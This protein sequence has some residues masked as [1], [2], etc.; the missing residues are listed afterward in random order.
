MTPSRMPLSHSAAIPASSICGRDLG[1][2][3]AHAR[4]HGPHLFVELALQKSVIGGDHRTKV[5]VAGGAMRHEQRDSVYG[6]RL[7]D[8][9]S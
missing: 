6:C 8:A 3:A 2:L 9:L 7:V 4:R 1:E 5:R